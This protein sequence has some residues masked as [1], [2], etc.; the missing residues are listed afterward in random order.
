MV[1]FSL[2]NNRFFSVLFIEAEDLNNIVGEAFR[3]VYAQQRA[4]VEGRRAASGS[5]STG[6]Q[7]QAVDGAAAAAT[8]NSS[9]PPQPPPVAS[10]PVPDLDSAIVKV[11]PYRPKADNGCTPDSGLRCV[12]IARLIQVMLSTLT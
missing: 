6:K 7:T 5:T 12:A 8:T 4:L 10:N 2:S 1:V 3:I 9:R 11:P